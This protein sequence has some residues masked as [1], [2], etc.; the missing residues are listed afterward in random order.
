M[1]P[2]TPHNIILV[3]WNFNPLYFLFYVFEFISVFKSN[4]LDFCNFIPKPFKFAY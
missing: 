1:L 4:K 2:P 3:E